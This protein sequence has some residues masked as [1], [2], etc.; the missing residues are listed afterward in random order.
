[1]GGKTVAKGGW[2]YI[3]TNKPRGVLY[4]GVT[5]DLTLRFWQ[6]RNGQGSHFARKYGLDTIVLAEQY[7]TIEEVIAR[8]K[9][10]KSWQRQW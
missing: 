3:L 6:H 4:I 2:A 9:P 7:P 10:L 1:M 5:A 8:E